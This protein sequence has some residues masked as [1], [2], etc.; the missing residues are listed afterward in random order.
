MNAFAYRYTLSKGVGKILRQY[1]ARPFSQS[2]ER[3]VL[4]YS[5]LNHIGFAQ[6]Y[7]FLFYHEQLK[8]KFG[9]E[10]RVA[11]IEILLEN[12]AGRVDQADVFLIQPWFTV[13]PK[14]LTS[15]LERTC[16][17][18]PSAR[19][20]F[21]DSYAHNDLRLAQHVDQFIH[22]YMK[23]SLFRDRS[24]YLRAWRGDTNL[25][26]YYG[27]LYGIEGQSV[28]W[29]TPM[30]LIGKLRLTPNFFTDPRFI[31][32]FDR[33][34]F[35]MQ[36]SRPID[37][38]ARFGSGGTGWYRAMRHGA[39]RTTRSIKGVRLTSEGTVSERD[40]LTEL[41][42]SKLCFSPFGY[43][44]VCWRDVE[45]MM[46]GSVLIKPDM[47]HLETLP[48]IYEANVTYLAVNWDF[49]NLEDVVRRALANPEFCDGIAR[50]AFNRI[51]VYLRSGRCVT[52]Y[53]C[54]FQETMPPNLS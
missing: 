12:T 34:L 46:C 48:N 51:G 27:D 50:N 38:H 43:G 52:D 19:I 24:L 39:S 2:A 29:N 5:C 13:D 7:P 21:L 25:T 44:E 40:F 4:I 36:K 9:V 22:L 23:K 31:N 17:N 41:K 45:A 16:N 47:R 26:E 1:L 10:V 37:I 3:R 28:D 35:L 32:G 53:A 11:P 54:L 18:N 20:T 49:S 30:S 14:A 33:P 8:Q 15:S 42:A 6:V